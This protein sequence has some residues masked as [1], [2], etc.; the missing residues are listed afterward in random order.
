MGSAWKKETREMYVYIS[1]L[2]KSGL[3]GDALQKAIEAIKGV[4]KSSGSPVRIPKAITKNIG[5]VL[6]NGDKAVVIRSKGGVFKVWSL[7][8]YERLVAAGLKASRNRWGNT[9]TAPPI[10]RR[11]HRKKKR[12]Q[13]V[14]WTQK[15]ENAEKLARVSMNLRK[16]QPA[17]A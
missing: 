10:P 14:H 8:G 1:R 9:K 3:T 4:T 7:A 16:K 2:R 11:K 12:K 15:P 13:Y 6:G 5:A 17:E